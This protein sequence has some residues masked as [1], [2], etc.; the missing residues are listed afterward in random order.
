MDRIGK[1]LK[2]SITTNRKY[3]YIVFVFFMDSYNLNGKK[4]KKKNG[5]E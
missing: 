5:K 1:V 4:K 3:I 2:V